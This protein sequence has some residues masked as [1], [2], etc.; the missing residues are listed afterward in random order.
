M[1]GQLQIQL[2]QMIIW[3]F[4]LVLMILALTKSN[5]AAG[6]E[7]LQYQWATATNWDGSVDPSLGTGDVII[8]TGLSN[9]PT[10]SATQDFTIGSG[11]QM[12]IEP[13]GKSHS[14]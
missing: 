14:R 7:Q 1:Q 10:G 4:E 13:G 5:T 9:Y 6:Q 8:P 11:K 3:K 12:I 2:F